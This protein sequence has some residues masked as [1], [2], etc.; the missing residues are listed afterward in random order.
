MESINIQY[1]KSPCGSLILGSYQD[2]LCLCDWQYRKARDSVDN[3]IKKNLKAI[4]IEKESAVVESTIKQLEEYFSYKRNQ[5]DIPLYLAGTDFQRSVWEALLTIPFGAV[6]SYAQ[7]AEKLGNKKA[8]RAVA[9]ANGA[10]AISILVPCHRIIG[11][12]GELIGYAGGLNVKEKLLNLERDL[13][14]RSSE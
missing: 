14:S 12:N 8:V 6:S 11:S 4:Y 13:F 5:F 3:R 1:Y 7:L 9:S 10:N 2:K